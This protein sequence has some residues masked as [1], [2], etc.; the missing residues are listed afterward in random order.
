MRPAR[1]ER[2]EEIRQ[3]SRET[4]V[5]VTRTP[6][7]WEEPSPSGLELTIPQTTDGTLATRF[8][9]A[10]PMILIP[11]LIAGMF[12][13]DTKEVQGGL[14]LVL[15]LVLLLIHVPVGAAMGIAGI[16]GLLAIGGFSVATRSLIQLPFT[17]VRGWSLS[18]IPMFILMGLLLWRAGATGRVYDAARVWLGWLPGGLAMTTNAAG[19]GLAA[20]SG[21]TIGITYAI[22]RI[23]IPEMLRSGYDR[24]LAAGSVLMAGTGG[25]LI[26]PSILSVV[27]AGVVEVPVGRQLLA[28]MLPG[29]VLVSSY[30]LLILVLS[31]VRPK[32]APRPETQRETWA[33]RARVAVRA[34]PV[35]TLTVI[36]LGGL[37]SGVFTATEAGAIGAL[38]ALVVAVFFLPRKDLGENV[39]LALVETVAAVGAIF[40]LLVGA[41]FLNRLVALSGLGAVAA[42]SIDGFGLS[43]LQFMFVMVLVYLALGLF[44]EPV[45]MILIT[46]PILLPSLQSLDI[47][48]VWFGAFVVLLGELAIL[49]P[50]V[51]ILAFV[52][53]KICQEREVNLGQRIT[54]GD[55]FTAAAWFL[56]I[57]V[58]TLLAI[59][60][61]PEVVLWLPDTA[62]R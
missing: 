4:Q 58:V 49:T 27:Y 30:G 62:G 12:V 22:G 48:L 14:G 57:S 5:D 1:A 24:R 13:I 3:A 8:A 34:W 2:G 6:S 38:F 16:L 44:M 21:S 7:D 36:V 10:V 19:A 26:P 33:T 31:I 55:V 39:R 9:V 43:A 11:A 40:F 59:I 28:G 51:G 56:P 20:V 60:L 18:V 23:A 61:F 17:A 29:V 41:A 45:A 53:Y 32:F 35:P 47:D 42:E 15:M 50:P 52:V 46:L 54:I 37:Y 25:Q